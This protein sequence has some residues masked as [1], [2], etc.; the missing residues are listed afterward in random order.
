MEPMSVPNLMPALVTVIGSIGV[1]LIAIAA[2]MFFRI[3]KSPKEESADLAQEVGMLRKDH[4]QLAN[5]TAV[6]SNEVRHLSDN[7]KTLGE[8]VKSLWR[9]NASARSGRGTQ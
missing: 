5:N 8:E 4:H 7:V 3:F 1:G 6:L 2:A 9:G